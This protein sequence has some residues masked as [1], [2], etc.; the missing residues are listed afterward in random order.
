MGQVMTMEEIKAQFK[1]E[2]V[3]VREPEVKENLLVKKDFDAVIIL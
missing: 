3:V 2:W 1:D